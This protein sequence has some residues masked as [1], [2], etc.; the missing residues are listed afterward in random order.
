MFS[1]NN[2]LVGDN[3]KDSSG[4]RILGAASELLSGLRKTCMNIITL[5]LVLAGCG[6]E[7]LGSQDLLFYS[8]ENPLVG[9]FFEFAASDV[10]GFFRVRVDRH[11]HGLKLIDA[12]FLGLLVVRFDDLGGLF[13]EHT[14]PELLGTSGTVQKDNN[15]N[16]ALLTLLWIDIV[17]ALTLALALLGGSVPITKL[18]NRV[19]GESLGSSARDYYE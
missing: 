5:T 18:A 17:A 7:T 4:V 8:L 2:T 19:S 14:C 9:E 6:G 10:I 13:D 15:L 11:L 16:V 3:V 12:V 1:A